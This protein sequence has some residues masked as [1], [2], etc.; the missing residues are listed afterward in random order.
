[1]CSA[2]PG[3]TFDTDSRLAPASFSDDSD[4]AL[5][6]LSWVDQ[7]LRPDLATSFQ[8]VLVCLG[9]AFSHAAVITHRVPGDEVKWHALECLHNV[10]FDNEVPAEWRTELFQLMRET[11]NLDWLLVTKRVGNVRLMIMDALWTMFIRTNQVPPA[12]PWANVWLGITVVN[13]DEVGRDIP[14]LIQTPAAV[15]FLSVEPL[16]GPF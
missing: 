8:C 9:L 13:Q 15:R 12:W 10:V 7:I 16:L 6:W 2:P 4:A 14:K 5:F 1:M 3:L 11:P